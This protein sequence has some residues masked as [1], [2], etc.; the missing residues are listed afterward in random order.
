M[1]NKTNVSKSGSTVNS[2]IKYASDVNVEFMPIGNRNVDY[3]KVAKIKLSMQTYGI[4]SGIVLVATDVFDGNIKYY[5]IDG[6]HRY[7]AAKALGILNRLPVYISHK[8]FGSITEIVNFVATLNSTQTPWILENYINAYA[9]IGKEDYKFL[10]K[11]H[12]MYNLSYNISIILCGYTSGGHS[13]N[14]VKEGNFTIKDKAKTL[15]I[16]NYIQDCCGI[17]G[18]HEIRVLS[19]F[20]EQFYNWFNPK[21]YKHTRF[22]V[23]LEKH[24]EE[25]FI[26]KRDGMKALLETFK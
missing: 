22:L 26:L 16:A 7:E 12:N 19:Y 8:K 5:A 2:Q 15:E 23:W 6:Q 4:T 13:S 24:K 14:S 1:K 18:L 9:S 3:R 20:A 17:I 10:Q 25:F 21:T 11:I